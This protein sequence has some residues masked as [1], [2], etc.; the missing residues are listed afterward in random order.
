[1]DEFTQ[2]QREA[3]VTKHAGDIHSR[4]VDPIVE[5]S[6][7]ILDEA[8]ERIDRTAKRLCPALL[9]RAHDPATCP[10]CGPT[11]YDRKQDRLVDDE[12]NER[13]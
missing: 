6:E 4:K 8:A 2:R 13:E 3:W 5:V 1:M 11:F 10:H 9:S 7:R 12:G